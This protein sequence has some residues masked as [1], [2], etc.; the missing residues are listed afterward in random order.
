MPTSQ[1]PTSTDFKVIGFPISIRVADQVVDTVLRWPAG[2]SSDLR[3]GKTMADYI[4]SYII[5]EL[6]PVLK[7]EIEKQLVPGW[8]IDGED[9]DG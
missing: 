1:E 8:S 2:I 3:S 9:L 4:T 6:S 5:G 7:R